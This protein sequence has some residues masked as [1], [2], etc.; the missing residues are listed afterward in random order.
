MKTFHIVAALHYIVKI[1]LKCNYIH[2]HVHVS[3]VHPKG[4]TMALPHPLVLLPHPL[5]FM[6]K[7]TVLQH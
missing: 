2:V 1:M 3:G 7:N 4:S 5:K 6:L